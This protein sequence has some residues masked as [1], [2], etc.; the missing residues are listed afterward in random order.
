MYKVLIMRQSP[1]ESKTGQNAKLSFANLDFN[2]PD[3]IISSP[4]HFFDQ[5][6]WP[7]TSF[8]LSVDD[9]HD[10]SFIHISTFL[11]VEES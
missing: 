2:N 8:L 10:I 1:E 3:L 6:K 7:L 5:S 11:V 9:Q 4:E